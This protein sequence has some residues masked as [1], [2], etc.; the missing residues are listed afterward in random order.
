M[1]SFPGQIGATVP[2]AGGTGWASQFAMNNVVQV[3]MSEV[4][5]Q[6]YY[7]RILY[8]QAG[9]QSLNFFA[10][11]IGQGVTT[12]LGA[13]VGSAKTIQDTNLEQANMIPNG[14]QFLIESIELKFEPG[15]SASANTYTVPNYGDFTAVAA[16]GTFG[17]T[18]DVMTFWTAGLFQLNILSKNYLQEWVHAFPPKTAMNGFTSQGNNSATTG[19]NIIQYADNYGRPYWLDPMLTLQ[20][21]VQFVTQIVYPAVVAMPSGFNGRVSCILD[22]VL[23]RAAQ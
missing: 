15:G 4:I 22:G 5:R 11:P 6:R 17:L 7:D 1:A 23:M 14:K 20:P 21:M 10:L 19:S 13:T 16:D 12:A 9:V 2:G 18:Q 8:G 3:G